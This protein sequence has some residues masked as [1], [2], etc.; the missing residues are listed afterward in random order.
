[1]RPE[2]LKLLQDIVTAGQ[3]IQA[4]MEG[5]SASAF[6]DNQNVRFAVE[7]NFIIIGRR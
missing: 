6:A 5:M 7:R 2:S 4:A 3:Y 1:M